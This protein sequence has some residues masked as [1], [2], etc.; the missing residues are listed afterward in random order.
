MEQ[1]L[2]DRKNQLSDAQEANRKKINAVLS[3]LRRVE[4]VQVRLEGGL[5][6]IE[7]LLKDNKTWKQD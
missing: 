3:E 5:L 6:E 1:Y 7:R 2:L 4:D